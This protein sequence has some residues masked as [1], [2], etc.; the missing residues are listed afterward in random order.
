MRRAVRLTGAL[1]LFAAAF[2]L[3]CQSRAEQYPARPVHIVVAYPAGSTMDVVARMLAGGLHGV[4]G[5]TFVVDNRPG[6]E[7][8]I[9]AEFVA[10][11][12]P[13]GYTLFISGSSTHSA[14]PALFKQLPYDPVKDFSPIT[15]IASLTYALAVNADAPVKNLRDLAALAASR[16]KGLSYAYGSQ[17][18]QIAAATI[19]KLTGMNALGVPYKGQPPAMTDLIGGEVDFMIADVP[20]LVPQIRAGK[21][22]ALAVFNEARSPLLPDVPTL[23]EQGITGYDLLG[24]IGLSAP[25]RTP[26]DIVETLYRAADEVLK[27]PAFQAKLTEMGMTYDPSSPDQFARLVVTQLSIWSK[28]AKDAGIAQE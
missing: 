18:A 26:Q 3:S 15:E 19:A 11:A 12:P 20:V 28:K 25:A 16:P 1:A 8:R 6:A 14:N 27:A 22:R 5:G 21:L 2:A 13:D 24:W 10:K 4:T 23:A 7:G 9:G 17:L